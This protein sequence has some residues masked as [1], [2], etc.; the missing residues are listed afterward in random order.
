M[1]RSGTTVPGKGCG[2]IGFGL[3]W[4]LFSSIF[5]IV[6][7]WQIRESFRAGSWQ[8][9]PC[10]IDRFEIVDADGAEGG[11]RA[12][13]AYRYD[14][15]GQSY[16]GTK[17]WTDQKSSKAY[18]EL[19]EIREPFLQGPEGR[20]PSPAGASAECRVNPENPAES[21]LHPQGS[22]GQ[23]I[24]GLIFSGVGGLFVLIGLA[25]LFS[26]RKER[27]VSYPTTTEAPPALG[28]VFFLIFG[29]AGLGIFGGLIVPKFLEWLDMRG[30]QETSAEVVRGRVR[31]S[32]GDDSTTY[33]VDLLYRYEVGGHEYR[34]NRY[35]LI[36]GSSSGRKG[37]VEV[38]NA[39]PPGTKITVFVDPQ[40]PWRAVINRN[41]GWWALFALFPL[42]FMAVGLG[43]LIWCFR[44]GR[45]PAVRSEAR[46]GLAVREIGNPAM[47]AGEWTRFRT[48]PL[49]GFIFILIFTLF[50]NGFI[51][52]GF[53]DTKGSF[54]TLF[55]I[56]FILVGLGMIAL[57]IYM[58]IA[59]FGPVY[60]L[61]MNE[62]ELARGSSHTL[63]WRR[64]GGRGQPASFCLLLVG[65]EE[66]TYRNGTNTSTAKLVFHEQVIFETRTPQ[67]MD[68]GHA[69]ILIP[70][71]AVPS[72]AG[73]HNR[74]RWFLC[75]R[76]EI[77]RLPDVK[78]EREITVSFPRK[79]ELP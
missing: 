70:A 36:G 76:A 64:G 40:N 53:F 69:T 26:S 28:L 16:T 63:R 48:V 21:Y 17:L 37:K 56:P 65:R 59:L 34:S 2:L 66:A 32:R 14:Y 25:I 43:G 27:V 24:F 49:A 5:L 4:T 3:F 18:Q 51:T 50:W 35:D 22:H 8:P 47:V 44:K 46:P 52:F 78:A 13:L 71:D 62:A 30:W 1:T 20:R 39:N 11:F 6:G 29:L 74:I 12:D 73:S 41:P 7:V 10:T 57:T 60:E 15:G 38:V 31:E 42:P 68:T 45:K 55:L 54:F 72:F 19:A 9:V 77:P 23:L 61:Q 67:A 33:A 58:F 79:E 75:L